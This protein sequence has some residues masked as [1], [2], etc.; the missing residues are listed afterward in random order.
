[1][2]K[3]D[4]LPPMMGWSTWNLLH[5]NIS[6]ETVIEVAESIKSNGLLAAG[7]SYINL[8]D[9]WQASTRDENMRLQFD[10]GLFPS[11]NGIVNKLNGLGFKAGIYS[12]S[13]NYTCEDMP[14]SYGFEDLDAKTFV[15]WGFE[16]LKYDY[17]HVVDLPTDPHFEH[18]GY[19][20]QTPPI[21]YVAISGLGSSGYEKVLHS[22][23]A[24]VTAPAYLKDG[25][26][27]GLHC[28]RAAAIFELDIPADGQYQLAI[29]Y[30]KEESPHKRFLLASINGMPDAQI[31]FP[32]TSGW[33]SP[34][35]ATAT[36]ILKA[37]KNTLMLTNPI[38]GQ[39]ED[40][41]LRYIRMGEA[42]KNAAPPNKPIYYSI[43]EHG[44]TK[45]W[46]W[47]KDVASSWRV[48]GDISDNWE[49]VVRN[50]EIAADLWE[51]Q[52]PGTY[53]DPDMLEVGVGNLTD[54]ENQSHFVLWCM[55]AAP[56]VLGLDVRTASAKTLGLIT[57]PE[58]IAINQD[59]L[60]LQ[61]SRIMIKDGLDLLIKPLTDGRCAVC[62]FNKSE[63]TISNITVPV[64]ML[65]TDR[66]VT[67]DLS[68]DI[69]ATDI[70]CGK[71]RYR[72][73]KTLDI[74]EIL[75][76]GVV[77]LILDGHLCTLTN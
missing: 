67:L 53:N 60:L 11:K 59:E 7:Y 38:R 61:A 76:H 63:M 10:V 14:G 55:L 15:E 16:L 62:L 42:L 21:L 5:Q 31:W 47:A 48:S 73:E 69:F 52:Q 49:A 54:L 75:P 44:R 65:L 26:I 20:N 77:L 34:A 30:V 2:A 13:G 1:M 32:P 12:S 70:L 74:Q 58:L 40:S 28:T 8:D 72:L 57:D 41:M 33:N 56:L 27:Y 22:N 9:C 6:E 68:K 71:T 36:V 18:Q 51:Y 19:A 37:G 64:E 46:T 17:C 23:V 39:R 50:Y 29:G 3:T 35:R 66:R 25:A 43:C 4:K 24:E 45:P